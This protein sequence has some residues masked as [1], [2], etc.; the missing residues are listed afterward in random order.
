[1]S[2]E[3]KG[4][5][6]LLG[7]LYF[8]RTVR[9]Q[10]HHL[11]RLRSVGEKPRADA[12]PVRGPLL[13]GILG[14]RL[15]ATNR[16]STVADLPAPLPSAHGAAHVPRV[17][18][19]WEND[20]TNL[21]RK[22]AFYFGLG[23]IFLRFSMIHELLTQLAGINLY[24]L[25]VIAPPALFGVLLSGGLRRTFQSR[26]AWYWTAFLFWMA[27]TVPFSVWKGG[28]AGLF[29][30]Y[31]K[32][33]FPML[34][35]TA[36]LA[37]T[38][39]ECRRMIHIIGLAALIYLG[40]AWVFM[41]QAGARVALSF[42][43]TANSNDLAA[44]LL[45]V[46]PFVL[47]LVLDAS[48][49]MLVRL[50]ALAAAGFGIYLIPASGSRGALVGLAVACGFILVRGTPW[51]RLIVL[52]LGVLGW[53]ALSAVV[54]A[55]TYRRLLTFT[56][57]EDASAEA[58][59]ASESRILLLKQSIQLTLQ[60][61]LFGVGPGQFMVEEDSVSRQEG[62]QRGT[63]KQTHN[64]YTQVSSECGIPALIFYVAG[65]VSS[66]LLLGKTRRQAR[67]DPR[68]Q[69]IATATFC[70]MVSVVG[71]CVA[72]TFLNTAYTFYLPAMAGLAIAVANAA[73]LEFSTS[74]TG[75]PQP[76]AIAVGPRQFLGRTQ[77]PGTPAQRS[78]GSR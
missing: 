10:P 28:S 26:T 55:E 62:N 53:V 6:S 65:I 29:Y 32:S 57:R 60:H 35:V 45:L 68:H 67:Q 56:D 4:G 22:L 17:D 16:P 47:F 24:P 77:R 44:H 5:A 36:G 20:R 58:L 27:V 50:G 78:R 34:L 14:R 43:T 39:V 76:A 49:P 66:F 9:P 51:L 61:P 70:M 21:V 46:L 40:V 74:G 23:L 8:K 48:K 33:E 75:T 2:L 59:M 63:W 31:V 64:V 37:V 42:G 19:Q 13:D 54:P 30:V 18:L 41:S 72:M 73:A 69:Q 52:T 11:P 38:W 15:L 3:D 12:W 7:E 1:M 71:F 25:Y